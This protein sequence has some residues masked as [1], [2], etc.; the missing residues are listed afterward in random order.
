MIELLA[1]NCGQLYS[2]VCAALPSVGRV[3][4]RR[5]GVLPGALLRA[6][7]EKEVK[8]LQRSRRWDSSLFYGIA[9]STRTASPEFV[10]RKYPLPTV[11]CLQARMRPTSTGL[12][13]SAATVGTGRR[14]RKRCRLAWTTAAASGTCCFRATCAMWSWPRPWRCYE[15]CGQAPLRGPDFRRW[16]SMLWRCFVTNP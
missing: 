13:V 3:L 7:R 12:W 10:E 14:G 1:S 5:T 4:R 15:F 6:K 16:K 9:R 8:R 2:A 11:H